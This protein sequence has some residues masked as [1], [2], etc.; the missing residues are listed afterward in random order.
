MDIQARKI[1]FIQE[2]LKI[3]NEKLILKLEN[4][5]NTEKQKFADEDI[6][7]MSI[8]EFNNIIDI[9]EEDSNN[10]RLTP[11]SKLIKDIDSWT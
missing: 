4:M 11:A 2:F 5:L 10:R 3:R 1:N 6:A 7:K 9:A 8:E